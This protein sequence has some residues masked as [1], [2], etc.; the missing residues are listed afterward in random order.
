MF[1]IG[2]SFDPKRDEENKQNTTHHCKANTFFARLRIQSLNDLLIYGNIRKNIY[3][4][5]S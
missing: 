2:N 1:K 5:T 3:L 4:P